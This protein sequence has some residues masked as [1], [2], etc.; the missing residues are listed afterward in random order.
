MLTDGTTG[1]DSLLATCD[2]LECVI[3]QERVT[4]SNITKLQP[5]G[6]TNFCVPCIQ[7]WLDQKTT[8]PMCR[9]EVLCTN[10]QGYIVRI[11]NNAVPAWA[12]PIR[13]TTM[14]SIRRPEN[15][16]AAPSANGQFSP[17]HPWRDGNDTSDVASFHENENSGSADATHAGWETDDDAYGQDEGQTDDDY[18]D[19]RL[20]DQLD[21]D[22][23]E[24]WDEEGWQQTRYDPEN[25]ES[26]SHLEGEVDGHNRGIWSREAVP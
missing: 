1:H 11:H 20:A 19:D 14:L 12:V 21:L 23:E 16:P 5:C 17:G 7:I 25:R 2:A 8:C 13:R 4:H 26:S 6:H 9:A 10:T 22:V 18:Y 24:P 3:C 15:Q